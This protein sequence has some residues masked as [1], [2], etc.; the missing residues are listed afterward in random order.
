MPLVLLLAGCG[1]SATKPPDASRLPLVDGATVVARTQQ[2]DRG[3]NA[4]CSVQLVVVDRRYRDSVDL[5]RHERLKLQS[6]GWSIND[7]DTGS[8]HAANSPGHRV[9]VTYAT[10]DGDL[11]GI[12]LG[13]IDRPRSIT[14]AL[15]QAIFA[16][17][18]AISMMIENGSG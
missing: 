1:S 2:C 5:M 4:F 14:L 15:S 16:R 9:R 11:R 8:E 3:A 7:G 17:S 6:L 10:A 12:V 13:W 18:P